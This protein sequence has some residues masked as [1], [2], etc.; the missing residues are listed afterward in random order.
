[1]SPSTETAE[2]LSAG[3]LTA[4]IAF[5]G[6]VLLILLIGVLSARFSSRGLSEFFLGGR[7]MNRFVVAL[8]AVVSGRSSWLLIGV[9]GMA[10]VRGLSAVWAITGYT[11]VEFLMFL[12]AAPRLRKVTG[13]SG[14]LTLPDF[15]VSRFGDRGHLLRLLT[16]AVIIVFMTAY[17]S[18]QFVG[19]GKSFAGSFGVDIQTGV[20]ITALVVLLY[21]ML[22]GFLAVSVT[23]VV[24]AV[25]MILSL[26]VLPI[27]AV[28]GLGGVD[29]VISTLQGLE[30]PALDPFAI[31]AGAMLGFLGIGFGSPGSPHILVR[32]MSIDDPAQLRFSAY[33][34]TF[35]NIVMGVAAVLIG[36]VGR[37]AVPEMAALPEGDAEQILPVLAQ[38]YLHPV[39]FGIVIASIMAAIMSTADSML[40]VCAS[41]LVRDLYQNIWRGG[42]NIDA[43]R[44][45]RL[46][47]S[48]IAVVVLAALLIGLWAEDLVFWL[49]L[50]AW[51]GLGA[52]FGPPLLLSLFWKG[53]TR[54][55]VMAGMVTG[56]IVT[57][58]W[59]QTT[60][61]KSYLYE[62]IP[63][64]VLSALLVVIISLLTKPRNDHIH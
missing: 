13:E 32:Y 12:Y 38:R 2:A 26:V 28:A 41:S 54:P 4:L 3:D 16:V 55:G 49:V 37:A 30:L 60:V 64:F 15:F 19:G 33:V 9:T 21:T 52:A 44:L 36:V 31:S 34:G 22:G 25:F 43:R 46:S 5:G 61:L 23:D 53:T 18:A 58:V 11:V 6:Y 27:M 7:A 56:V 47:R 57:I 24:Q 50:F 17:I 39:L 59:K 48:F 1:M 8:S 29:T 42:E 62:L 10:Y 45:V 20:L 63:A 35:W 40:L 51:S 14:D